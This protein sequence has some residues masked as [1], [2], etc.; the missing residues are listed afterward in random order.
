MFYL[1]H[2][3]VLH[4]QWQAGY[5]VTSSD[6]SIVGDAVSAITSHYRLPGYINNILS[7]ILQYFRGS[8]STMDNFA[9]V[10]C[11]FPNLKFYSVNYGPMC[12]SVHNCKQKPDKIEE[13]LFLDKY[14]LR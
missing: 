1:S 9:S 12:F 8:F 14:S 4:R 3:S 7:N 2:D 11:P 5:N 13:Q 10:T 6:Y